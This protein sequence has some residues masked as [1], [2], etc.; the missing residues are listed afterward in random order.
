MATIF[1]K[2]FEPA[3]ELELHALAAKWGLRRDSPLIESFARHNGG[4]CLPA[5]VF[6]IDPLFVPLLISQ[7]FDVRQVLDRDEYWVKPPEGPW[8]PVGW[9]RKSVVVFVDPQDSKSQ[10]VIQPNGG[11]YSK[12]WDAGRTQLI[13]A[14]VHADDADFDDSSVVIY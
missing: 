9:Y 1:K 13:D 10:L 8:Y 3:S 5:T 7:I 11:Q 14:L 2:L 4:R 6:S 12:Y